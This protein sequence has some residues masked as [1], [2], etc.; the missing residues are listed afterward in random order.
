MNEIEF[1]DPSDIRAHILRHYPESA[2]LGELALKP[3]I[4][5]RELDRLKSDDDRIRDQ[6]YR[7]GDVN[8]EEGLLTFPRAIDD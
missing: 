3:I 8:P 6:R 5:P 4:S 2:V 1:Q 7:L